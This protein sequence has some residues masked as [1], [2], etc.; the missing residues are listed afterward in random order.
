MLHHEQEIKSKKNYGQSLQEGGTWMKPFPWKGLAAF[1]ALLLV[2]LLAVTVMAAPPTANDD[3]GAV[4]E[5]DPA[6]VAID[7]LAN[8]VDGGDGIDAT[9]VTQG[10]TAPS[11][12][13][14][15][16][17]PITGVITYTPTTA[18]FYGT[19]VFTYTVNDDLGNPSNEA[20]VTVTVNPVNDDPPVAEDDAVSTPNNK[21]FE[22]DILANDTDADEPG[23]DIDSTTVTIVVNGSHGTATVDPVTG[24]VTYDPVILD[25]G[26]LGDDTFTYTVDDKT[27]AN[28][29]NIATVTV[30]Q[31]FPPPQAWGDQLKANYIT[32]PYTRN[33][34]DSV[35]VDSALGKWHFDAYPRG[36]TY[37]V[38]TFGIRNTGVLD[39]LT[40]VTLTSLID[41]TVDDAVDSLFIYKDDGDSLFSWADD[42]PIDSLEFGTFN[43][44]ETVTFTGMRAELPAND[45]TFFHILIHI[46]SLEVRYNPDAYADSGI[47]LFIAADGGLETELETGG[48]SSEVKNP[49]FDP[50]WALVVPAPEEVRAAA[51]NVM[52]RVPSWGATEELYTWFISDSLLTGNPEPPGN[53][54]QE[55]R[56]SAYGK[57]HFDA[58]ARD[59]KVPVLTFAMRNLGPS[60]TL[61]RIAFTS[62][63]E[64]ASSISKLWLYSDGDGDSVYTD[65]AEDMLYM[66]VNPGNFAAGDMFSIGPLNYV[67]GTDDTTYF[68]IVVEMNTAAIEAN[69]L[70]FDHKGV[71]VAIKG[72]STFVMSPSS[73]SMYGA[74]GYGVHAAP[75]V[76]DDAVLNDPTQAWGALVGFT[77]TNLDD[78][79][80]GPITANTGTTIT[81]TLAGGTEDL[82]DL[83]DHYEITLPMADGAS[84]V[85]NPCYAGNLASTNPWEY[86]AVIGVPNWGVDEELWAWYVSDSLLTGNPTPPGSC[87][88]EAVD[89]AYDWHFEVGPYG[90][91]AALTF[92]IRNTGPADTLTSVTVTSQNGMSNTIDRLALYMDEGDSTFGVGDT[93]LAEVA[94]TDPWA[95]DDPDSVAR[96]NG[97]R[98]ELP[99]HDTTYYH[100]VAW[101]NTAAIIGSESK[102]TYQSYDTTGVGVKIA[103]DSIQLV[104]VTGQSNDVANPCPDK[105]ASHN[106]IFQ[107][108]DWDDGVDPEDDLF[109]TYRASDSTIRRPDATGDYDDM[110]EVFRFFIE[111]RTGFL[112]DTLKSLTLTSRAT[113]PKMVQRLW[114]YRDMNGNKRY[115]AGV[116]S[117]VGSMTITSD[118]ADGDTVT[119]TGLHE[120]IPGPDSTYFFVLVDLNEEEINDSP[121]AFMCAKLNVEIAAGDIGMKWADGTSHLVQRPSGYALTVNSLPI[122]MS[123]AD[124]TFELFFDADGNGGANIGDSIRIYADLSANSP[125]IVD[126][127][128]VWT[129]LSWWYASLNHVVLEDAAGDYHFEARV[130]LD[131]TGGLLDVIPPDDTLDITVYARGTV[132]ECNEVSEDVSFATVD[133][134][135]I[136]APTTWGD[137]T[138]TKLADVDGN[139]CLGLG[140]SIKIEVAFGVVALNGDTVGT[141][142]ELDSVFANILDAGLGGPEG[143]FFDRVP[144]TRDSTRLDTV[145]PEADPED[146]YVTDSAWFSLVWE[147]KEYP[148]DSAVDTFGNVVTVTI[149]GKDN[150]G[151][152]DTTQTNAIVEPV[153]TR[154]P[155]AISGLTAESLPNAGV[156]LCW[157]TYAA[158]A[159]YFL[160]YHDS[161]GVR[162]GFPDSMYSIDSAVINGSLINPGGSPVCWTSDL[163]TG[164]E[165]GKL[166]KFIVRTMDDC[167]NMEFNT[168]VV[169]AFTDATPAQSCVFQ[170]DTGGVYSPA[171]P[172]T[173]Y[174]RPAVDPDDNDLAAVKARGRLA[175]R[176][177][178]QPGPWT[179]LSGWI[180]QTLS[181]EDI[182]FAIPL[183]T[184][185]LNALVGTATAKI[186][187]VILTQDE[188]G[189][190]NTDAEALAACDP[191][192]WFYWSH[193]SLVCEIQTINGN[194][195][196]YQPYCNDIGFEVYGDSN[197]VALHVEGGAEPYKVAAWVQAP[198]PPMAKRAVVDTNWTLIFYAEDQLA[199]VSFNLDA[200][201]FEKGAWDLRVWF[202]D[203]SHAV[204]FCYAML[205]VPD[206]IAPCAIISKPVDGKCIRRSLSQNDP[207]EICATVDPLGNCIDPENVLKIDFQWATLCCDDYAG[208]ECRD[209]SWFELEPG[210]DTGSAVCD[211]FPSGT[212]GFEID[213]IVCVFD[214]TGG[215]TL[216]RRDST[217]C[218]TV[219]C[220][221]LW[222]SIES[223]RVAERTAS[224]GGTLRIWPG[225]PHRVR[226]S[227]SGRRFTT[228]RVTCSPRNVCRCV[229]TL[230]PRRCVSPVLMSVLQETG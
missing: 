166:Y 112:D 148:Q 180:T 208:I 40:D 209:T 145:D 169:A 165:D 107:A 42:E 56:D 117:L 150:A 62:E 57:W 33:N 71:G 98:E 72:D 171:I 229:W 193:V 188:V 85:E 183:D 215:Y 11:D 218:D 143:T 204:D 224:T 111:H 123:P 212:E 74:D 125:V 216:V 179:D 131:S 105:F 83:D 158:D 126:I 67:L 25:P 185:A 192:F 220:T 187:L 211:T 100:V 135:D 17:D 80:S 34:C 75:G 64:M 202:K 22:I 219:E 177:D 53:C 206:T 45:T 36:G 95:W 174:V 139:G 170:P 101:M 28:T 173:V 222:Y 60:D 120:V 15:A 90:S 156:R 118:F 146:L 19:D 35:G 26:Y 228:T 223:S 49:C 159:E 142:D 39:N 109:A 195:P 104:F 161:A 41:A 3:A 128:E 8:D 181:G 203:A 140:D 151:N 132:H 172:L 88:Q 106:V 199:D 50:Y 121:L 221:D 175:D 225:L 227:T 133:F 48:P 119:F 207:V 81:A 18:D 29:S 152:Y 113:V 30:T 154:I 155:E 230:I 144:L 116:D 20:T 226:T 79:S 96:F 32:H 130:L 157:T 1:A 89:S 92:A 82:W 182:A 43:W 164:L 108:L 176:G 178:G 213:S 114:L 205:C 23:F 78:G 149:F 137:R 76:D 12:G 86:G 198:S 196:L 16:I 190:L 63:M 54:N 194:L 91:A 73:Y 2:P 153:D 37:P 217:I 141:V 93:K 5:D 138:F 6:G 14:I 10:A 162:G 77:I 102:A 201:D 167:G 186:E 7:V 147:L 69:P 58:F 13:S 52:M 55:A 168:F 24:I 197:T 44:T 122:L 59:D 21:I 84:T 160:I 136:I 65:G 97:F 61:Q 200:S 129:D 70:G 163:T 46:D 134:V 9:S 66:K 27:T 110:I 87:T 31:T 68:H 51:F 94:I 191:V 99:G 103:V 184:A 127:A 214:T 124:L 189:N 47:G 38:L 115:T 4:N 210:A